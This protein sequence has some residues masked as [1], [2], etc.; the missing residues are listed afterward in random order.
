MQTH[1]HPH[2]SEYIDVE[3]KFNLLDIGV[4]RS[5]GIAWQ[6]DQLMYVGP[7]V[8]EKGVQ[9]P[10]EAIRTC[11]RTIKNIRARKDLR[12]VNEHIETIHKDVFDIFG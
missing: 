7:S 2:W 11:N 4:N 10:L 12:I 5:H 8:L 9:I 6:I 3:H 1:K